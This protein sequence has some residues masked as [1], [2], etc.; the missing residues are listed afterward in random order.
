MLR[1]RAPNDGTDCTLSTAERP[2]AFFGRLLL[3]LLLLL[4]QFCIAPCA[5]TAHAALTQT[6][7]QMLLCT[8]YALCG[9]QAR[10]L[11]YL[12]NHLLLLLLRWLR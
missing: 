3:L 8:L 11:L 6:R 1:S 2:T 7:A 5:A 12:L 9:R 10:V 4:L